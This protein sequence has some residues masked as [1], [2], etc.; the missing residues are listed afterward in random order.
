M[1]AM[2]I[3]FNKYVE[4]LLLWVALGG[5][6]IRQWVIPDI[7]WP[8]QG[9]LFLLSFL[10]LNGIWIFHYWFN[11]YL[12]RRL[13]FE[14]NIKLRVV[15]QVVGGWTFVKTIFVFIIY[16]V[17][18]HLFSRNFLEINIINR[19]GVV[20]IGITVFLANTA[21][22]LGFMASHFLKR[23]QENAV[24]A[25]QL[26]KE[27]VQVQLDSLKNQISPHFLF[28]SLSSLDGLIHENPDLASQFLRQ[29]SK[30]F[31]YVIQHKDKDLVSLKTE[32]DFINTYILLLKTRFNGSLDIA[33]AI[34]PDAGE[35]AIVPVTLQILIENAVKHNIANAGQ[36]L[37]IQICADEEYLTVENNVQRKPCVETSNGHGLTNLKALYHFLSDKDVK[38]EEQNERFRVCVPLV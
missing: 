24:R 19:F 31:R 23:W 26:E 2:K 6:V 13:P 15:I 27:K 33:F 36:P 9:G 17:A 35:K 37:T 20:V 32:V 11:D 1:P 38:V 21:A 30:V 16:T 28:N 5:I 3:K 22:C 7:T 25:A 29:L 18:T 34:P 14:R 4:L 10:V 12:N 8:V